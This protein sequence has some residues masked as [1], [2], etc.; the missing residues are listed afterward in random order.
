MWFE[1]MEEEFDIFDF[2]QINRKRREELW[3]DVFE[4]D[5]KMW[6]KKYLF[7]FIFDTNNGERN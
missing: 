2:V 4:C 6:K 7:E 5:F 3:Y 1:D